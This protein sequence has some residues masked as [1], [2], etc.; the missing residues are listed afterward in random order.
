MNEHEK[1]LREWIRKHAPGVSGGGNNEGLRL[2]GLVLDEKESSARDAA[3]EEAEA[4]AKFEAN[5]SAK[6]PG[7]CYRARA[8]AADTII[9]GIRA[10]QSAPA[11]V[12]SVEKVREEARRIIINRLT[13]EGEARGVATLA[14]V[15]GANV[16]DLD[17]APAKAVTRS[18]VHDVEGSR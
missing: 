8:S 16:D 13:S 4:V 7:C 10:L 9:F 12:V 18:D 15:L 2:L 1:K 3:L 14:D 6:K 17:A 5:E 11:Q